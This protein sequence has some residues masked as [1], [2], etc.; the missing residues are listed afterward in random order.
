MWSCEW[1]HRLV[2]CS[3]LLA[4]FSHLLNKEQVWS[5]CSLSYSDSP[6]LPTIPTAPHGSHAHWD[7]MTSLTKKVREME[8]RYVSPG[9]CWVHFMVQNSQTTIVHYHSEIKRTLK[10]PGDQA[11]LEGGGVIITVHKWSQ[12]TNLS[13]CFRI[14]KDPF[15]ALERFPQVNG[16]WYWTMLLLL[17]CRLEGFWF[18]VWR[19]KVILFTDSG[20]KSMSEPSLFSF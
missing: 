7:K 10:D 2:R 14:T 8:L 13:G 11:E 19:S 12:S 16:H 18:H 17:K 5:C 15:R 6:L 20:G 1:K 3:S 9:L 4:A